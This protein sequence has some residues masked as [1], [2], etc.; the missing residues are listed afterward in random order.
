M[1]DPLLSLAHSAGASQTD[2]RLEVVGMFTIFVRGGVVVS[3]KDAKGRE[4]SSDEY[5]IVDY[6]NMEETSEK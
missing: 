3:V 6:D 4:L 5:E 2:W 1:V